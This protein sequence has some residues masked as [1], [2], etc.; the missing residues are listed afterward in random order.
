[1]KSALFVPANSAPLKYTLLGP[2]LE[3]VTWE[4]TCCPF[5]TLPKLIDGGVKRIPVPLLDSATV[6]GLVTS[7][8]ATLKVPE[9]YPT[10]VGLKATLMMHVPGFAMT[11]L[12]VQVVPLA[13]ANGPVRVSAGFPNVKETPLEFVSVTFVGA[14]AAPTA[15]EAN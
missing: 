6:W 9:A 3:I 15:V 14:L 4:E 2:T 10:F 5:V 8:S 11:R 12:F 7:V 1:M 13:S